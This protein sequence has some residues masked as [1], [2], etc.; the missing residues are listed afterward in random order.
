MRATQSN[1]DAL[2][3]L[4]SDIT[5]RRLTDPSSINAAFRAGD[6]SQPD[7]Q[8]MRNLYD[9]ARDPANSRWL[10]YAAS[11]FNARFGAVG[12]PAGMDA[13]ETAAT[14]GGG[15]I[16]SGPVGPP[17]NV[18]ATSGS[19]APDTGTQG[20]GDE[21]ISAS[22]PSSAGLFPSFMMDLDDAVRGQDLKPTQIRD[23][24]NKMLDDT[25]R[26]YFASN[27]AAQ[28][29]AATDAGG[30]GETNK[31]PSEDNTNTGSNTNAATNVVDS[32]GNPG[33]TSGAQ[34]GN[35]DASSDAAGA[36]G[37][38]SN[39]RGMVLTAN[40]DWGLGNSAAESEIQKT[41]GD[42]GITLS[43]AAAAALRKEMNDKEAE[44]VQD[45][46]VSKEDKLKIIMGIGDRV[47]KDPKASSDVKSNLRDAAKQIENALKE[48][49][50]K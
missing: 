43:D 25:Q 40:F 13:E 16:A 39:D 22:P 29:A 35:G 46:N 30:A 37:D 23:L 5:A 28:P 50:P 10:D 11:A 32:T 24:T 44:K 1:P 45:K 7:W 48:K 26:L 31:N 6:I 19:A 20:Q 4:A 33:Q 18:D 38:K 42:K 21:T 47:M 36:N 2:A 12:P 41:A 8:N 3:G 34:G 27:T 14:S 15:G 17:A 49:T 9:T